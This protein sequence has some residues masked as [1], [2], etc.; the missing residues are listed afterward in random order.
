[1]KTYAK[2]SVQAEKRKVSSEEAEQFAALGY[3]GGQV[4]ET[5][6]DRSKDPKDYIGAWNKNLEA[7]YLVE[8]GE[9]AKALSL[10]HDIRAGGRLPA[11]S[12]TLLEARCLIGAG[13]AAK[14]ETILKPAGNS[15]G[16]L[17][18]LAS[19]YAR[20]GRLQEANAAYSRVLQ[21]DFSYFS[22]FDYVL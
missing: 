15:A 22:L 17:S 4:S 8:H 5:S 11:E 21:E 1:Q 6:W 19:L 2:E 3:L 9:Y 10:I 14:A 20:T 16:A 7:S 13:D 12:L 18:E